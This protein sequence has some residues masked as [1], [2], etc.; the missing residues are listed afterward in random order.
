MVRDEDVAQR[1]ERDARAHERER[2]PLAAVDHVRHAAG[3]EEIARLA[4]AL[5][6]DARAAAG[7]EQ[8]QPR[9]RALRE[10]RNRRRGRERRRAAQKRPARDSHAGSWPLAANTAFAAGRF[11]NA[12]SA[13]AASA[14]GDALATPP[15]N[16]R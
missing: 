16:T 13:F 12:I 7:A 10:A 9:L 15:S 1:V 3:D 11:R 6:G 4:A 14:L 5:G 2:D 8:H